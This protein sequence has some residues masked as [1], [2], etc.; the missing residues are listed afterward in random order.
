MHLCKVFYKSVAIV[1]FSFALG[2]R[3]ETLFPLEG[4]HI[5]FAYIVILRFVFIVSQ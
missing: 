1:L 3:G 4:N 2:R 5:L